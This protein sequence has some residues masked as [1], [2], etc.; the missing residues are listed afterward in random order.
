MLEKDISPQ[1]GMEEKVALISRSTAE[2][3][4][5]MEVVQLRQSSAVG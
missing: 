1:Y 2:I 4:V 3:E 5:G